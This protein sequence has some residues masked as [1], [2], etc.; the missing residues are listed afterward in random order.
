MKFQ[1]RKAQK[2]QLALKILCS[3]SS[4]SGK[5]KSALRL[6]TGIVG[7]TGGSI[8]LIN[9]EGDRGE[10]YANEFDYQIIDLPEPRSP[11]NYIEAIKYC[12]N[13]GAS[14][15]IIDSLSH[16]W[17]YLNEQVNNMQG[18][19]FNNWGRQK[20]RHRKLVDFIVEAKVHI[21]ATGR[22][23]DEYVM[24][25]N[26]KGKSTP[27]KIGVGIQQEKDTEYEYMVTFNIAQDTHVAT[28]MKDNTG[29]FNNKF[30]VLTEKDGEAL[31]DWA[32]SGVEA[33]F[34]ISKAQQDIIN[35]ATELGGS[36]DPDVTKA[37]INIL[38]EANPK[39]C[40]DEVLLKQSLAALNSLKASRGGNK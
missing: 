16:E 19:S 14:V 8:Y 21:I 20:P 5:T 12:M 33:P 3:G 30:D 35:L 27:K 34:N 29:L 2:R 7:K 24:E 25:V 18:N 9:T 11:E 38:G 13:E 4:G 26:D 36:K 32:N 10:M 17:N 40:T 37:T 28:C 1:S 31:Y 23:K 15:I 6:A 22:G 39:N